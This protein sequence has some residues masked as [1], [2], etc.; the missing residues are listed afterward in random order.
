[1]VTG[2][3]DLIPPADEEE[4]YTDTRHGG[5]QVRSNPSI[6]GGTVV[7]VTDDGVQQLNEPTPA[8]LQALFEATT[9]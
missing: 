6:R 3:H 1:V 7:V 4:D 8:E 5:L 9:L 2:T